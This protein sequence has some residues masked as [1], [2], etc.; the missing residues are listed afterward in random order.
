MSQ[1]S[2]LLFLY[3]VKIVYMHAWHSKEEHSLTIVYFLLV[4]YSTIR[5]KC[6]ICRS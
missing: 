5:G 3:M 6:Y 1:A 2:L 4:R